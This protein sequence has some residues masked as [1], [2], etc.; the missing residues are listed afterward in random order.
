[1]CAQYYIAETTTQ[2]TKVEFRIYFEV[3]NIAWHLARALAL[4]AYLSVALVA[5]VLVLCLNH[6]WLVT[7]TA[8]LGLIFVLRQDIQLE[9]QS[10]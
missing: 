8:A 1:V 2:L 7:T 10:D 6:P 3:A 5:A 9:M 4:V